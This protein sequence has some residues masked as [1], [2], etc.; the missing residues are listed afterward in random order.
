MA[1]LKVKRRVLS[2][3]QTN[4]YY[5]YREGADD[6]VIIDP[7]S[8][9][10]I[11]YDDIKGLGFEKVAGILLTHGHGDH[12]GGAR[13][14]K[15]LSGA[16]IYAYEDEAEILKDPEKNLSGWFGTAYGFEADE[17]FHDKQTF[18][19]AGVTFTVFYT[20]GHTKGGCCYYVEEDGVLFCGDTIFN[21]S[22][23]RTDF[24][25]GS[26][27]E[28]ARSIRDRI[29][30]LPDETKL[31]SGHGDRTTVEYERKYNPCL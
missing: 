21:G 10:E 18:T 28:L 4:C 27:N 12:T 11:V 5:V 3:C 23:G 26:I 14:L 13:R 20:P 30:T 24:Y 31:Y 29:L 19:M 25:S 22:V 6:I 2:A 9:G 15:E 8:N 17:Y 1:D 7:G 16:K